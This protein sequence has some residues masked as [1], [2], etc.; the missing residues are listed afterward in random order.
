[1]QRAG[2]GTNVRARR[3]TSAISGETRCPPSSA[4]GT[5]NLNAGGLLLFGGSTLPAR[6]GRSTT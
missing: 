1:M 3:R 4:V 2:T 5:I 6:P